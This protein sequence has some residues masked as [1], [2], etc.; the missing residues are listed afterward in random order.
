MSIPA[1]GIPAQN[2]PTGKVVAEKPKRTGKKAEAPV[3]VVEPV[4]EEVVAPTE[5]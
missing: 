5:E 1:A 2:I 3:E 4:A